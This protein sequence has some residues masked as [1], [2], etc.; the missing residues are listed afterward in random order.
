MEEAFKNCTIG[1]LIRRQAAK[2]PDH[3]ALLTKDG[4][5]QSYADL[6]QMADRVAA[7]LLA[8]K[9]SPSS[10]IAIWAMNCHTWIHVMVGTARIGNLFIGVNTGYQAAELSQI[11]HHSDAEVL[12]F[13]E[14]AGRAGL[15]S[16]ILAEIL[17]AIRT[18]HAELFRSEL[19]PSLRYV[20]SMGN[21]P[22]PGALSWD[23]F[24]KLG[25]IIPESLVI[26]TQ[27]QV[28]PDDLAMIMYTSGTTGL[29]KG[30]MHSH[31]DLVLNAFLM[32]MRLGLSPADIAC[33]PPP[34]FH[35]TGITMPFSSFVTGGSVVFIERFSGR[36]F[37]RTIEACRAS[38]VYGVVTMF[39]AALEE[40]KSG[41]YDICSLRCGHI[42]GSRIPP[43]LVLDI[44][45]KMNIPGFM[46][47]Y[48]STEVICITLCKPDDSLMHRTETLGYLIEGGEISI[49]D[50]NT[51]QILR[52]GDIGEAWVRSPWM[53][54]G[55]YKMPD[56]TATVLDQDGFFKTGD[57]LSVD[58]DGY[59]RFTGRIDELIIRGGENIYAIEIEE[60]LCSHP[61][62][63]DARVVGIPCRFYGEDIVA[64]VIKRPGFE[65]NSQEIKKYL[66]GIIAVHKVPSAIITL[67]QFPMTGSG[68]VRLSSL[69]ELAVQ[70]RDGRP[71][72]LN[73]VHYG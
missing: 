31:S 8:L 11:L 65:I 55:Y 35:I 12:F 29:S 7:S 44:I 43:D 40:L 38:V 73:G 42:A 19:F 66:R 54:K 64:F 26:E 47:G 18:T 13:G 32:A 72:N 25:E 71:G 68:K 63:M 9:L 52:A 53:L 17:P 61:A 21:S 41:R 39:T 2:R 37:L 50:P 30:V 10:H 4:E 20:I 45:E 58:L 49:R 16:D 24:I 27:D 3:P 69:R 51:G 56:G 1:G 48:G 22:Y 67:D 28:Q 62:V 36:E 14:G 70:I 33:I 23:E 5:Y 46:V 34:L 6:D 15:F 57:L 59:F 60:P